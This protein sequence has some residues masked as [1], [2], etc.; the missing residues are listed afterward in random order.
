MRGQLPTGCAKRVLC[1][2]SHARC[3][4]QMGKALLNQSVGQI[5]LL[6]TTLMHQHRSLSSILLIVQVQDLCV[7]VAG[8]ME[9]P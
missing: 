3:G 7:A 2:L 5:N 6:G 4:M 8:T 9:Y 1:L